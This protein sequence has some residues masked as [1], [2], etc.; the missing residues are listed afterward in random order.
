MKSYL[1]RETHAFEHEV[2]QIL[3]DA[4]DDAWARVQAEGLRFSR[5]TVRQML[6]KY[7]VDMA[8]NGERDRQRLADVAVSRLRL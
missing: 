3:S 6:A 5:H 1:Q 7:I 4:L 8:K 2:I